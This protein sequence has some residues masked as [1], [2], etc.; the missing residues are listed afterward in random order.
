MFQKGR[1]VTL[2]Y[3]KTGKGRP[4]ILLHGNG[5][6]HK[7][8][9]KLIPQL[10]ESHTVYAIDS[11]GHG[12]STRVKTLDYNIMAEDTVEF[13]RML[14]IEKPVLY[15]FSDGGI[16][17]LIIAYKYPELLS[18]L[19]ISGANIHPDGLKITYVK[20]F[21]LI[22]LITRSSKYLLMLTQPNISDED[23]SRIRTQTYVL[24]G[25]NDMI[26]EEHTR[27]ISECIP[28]STVKILEGEN[29]MSYVIHSPKLYGIIKPFLENSN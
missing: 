2:Y 7:I 22:Y 27:H 1:D 24:A 13:I 8:F 17:G 25:S 11:R 12:K 16:L 29:H 21:R 26:E 19:I 28:K 6:S 14:N 9:D 4:I 3:E 15:G 10:S 23:L 20:L 5:E 18:K